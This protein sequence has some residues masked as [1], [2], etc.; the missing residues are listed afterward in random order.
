MT[1]SLFLIRYGEL[2]LKSPKVRRRFEKAL[3]TNIEDAFLQEGIQCIT[4]MDWGR[5]YLH[6]ESDENAKR[7]LRK[8][9]GIT[10]FS[11]VI[12]CTSDMDEIR[13]CASKYSKSLLKKENSFAVRASRTGDHDFTSQDVAREVG[14][15]ILEV[16]YK[17]NI[18]VDLQHPDIEIYVEVRH[19]HGFV[20]SERIP[21]PGGFPKG[22]Q[23]KVLCLITDRKSVYASWLLL[24]RGCNIRSFCLDENGAEL[25]EALKLWYVNSKTTMARDPKNPVNNA[26]ECAKSI[27]ADALV[28]GHTFQDYIKMDKITSELPIFYP[29]IGMDETE[30]E[31]NLTSL[32]GD[33]F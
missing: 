27:R 19:N 29:L 7:I 14:S 28:L 3:K 13:N 10:S 24:K 22:T 17:K 12:E 15:A 4:D 2:G 1:M 23:G 26:L 11:P 20:F 8:I 9:V 16:N 33:D 5:I 21:G 18:S 6:T 25:S 31:K 30:I 32:F